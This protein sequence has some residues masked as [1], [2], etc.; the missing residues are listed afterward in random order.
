M[1]RT[2]ESMIIVSSSIGEEAAKKENE[3]IHSLLKENDA[4][5]I[6]T[7]DWGKRELAY[8]ITKMKE[9]YYFINYFKAD[10]ETIKK[11]EKLYRISENII[12]FNI[13]VS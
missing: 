11:L 12:R 8:E 2:Y 5:V 4:E 6:K 10:A 9:G 7:D 1:I 13:V 3:K